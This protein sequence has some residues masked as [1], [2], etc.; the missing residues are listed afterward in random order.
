MSIRESFDIYFELVDDPRSQAHITYKLSDILFVLVTGMLCSCTDL[1]MVI[2]FAEEKSDFIKKYTELEE[3]PCLS[4]ITNILKV[5]NPEHLELCLYGI[6]S[7]VLK[8]KMNIDEKQICIDG[9]TICSTVNMKE[10]ERPMHII[11]ALLADES[12]SLGQ[13][14]VESKS[15]EIP[16]VRELLGLIDV[17]GAIVTMDAM[18][19]QKE[20]AELVIANGG[21]YVLQLKANQGRLY[22]DVYAMFDDKYRDDAEQESEYEVYETIE[23]SHGR[24]ERRKCYVLKEIEYFTEYTQEWK[25]LKKIFAVEREIEKDGKKTK[26]I[27]CYISSKNTSAEK[28]LS[29]TR[30]HWQ[31]ESFH[32]LLDMNYDEDSSRVVNKNS[33]I[34][35]NIIRK[36]C[37]SIIKKYIENHDVK[38]KTIVAN[39]RKCLLNEDFLIEVLEYYCNSL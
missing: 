37:I 25:G 30:K 33:Q 32:W 27:S 34:C 5:I 7:N 2:E 11:T 13:I 20:T 4:T 39:M 35:L 16:A 26:E 12:V 15:N 31:V 1:E 14:T 22:K 8:M 6:F 19:C 9:K 23:K 17:K 18:H 38:R 28:L 36:Y 29:Y 3:I 10:Y 21:D 24:I